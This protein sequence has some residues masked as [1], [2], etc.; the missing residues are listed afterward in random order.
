MKHIYIIL[1]AL[2]FTACRE[3]TPEEEAQMTLKE[4]LEALNKDDHEAYLKYV[5]MGEEMDPAKTAY[6][7]DVLRQ[8]LGWRRSERPAVVA[9]DMIDAQMEGDSICTVYYQYTFSDGTNEVGA[10]KMVRYGE[11]WKIRLRN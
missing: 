2:C 7:K 11:A 1:L 9:I 10:Q 5:D 3:K 4:A 6:M 8:H